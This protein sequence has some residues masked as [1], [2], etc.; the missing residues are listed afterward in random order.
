MADQAIA[1]MFDGTTIK[2]KQGETVDVS[3][4][5]EDAVIG[6][7]FSAHWCPPCRGFT[8]QLA[9]FYKKAKENGKHFEVIFL[10]SDQNEAQFNEYYGEMPWLTIDFGSPK[11]E[12]LSK[13]YEVRGIPT[14]I[15]L[16]KNG[17]IIDKEGRGKVSGD[18][19]DFPFKN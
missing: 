5:P 2:N 16:D 1:E 17:K 9:T 4:I 18:Y 7:Y 15:L 19:K 10:S 11:K 6:L 3:T 14:L 13:K 12:E 8:P